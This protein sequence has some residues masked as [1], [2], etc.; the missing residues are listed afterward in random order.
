M[1]NA[2]D[3]WL[4]A[5]AA[6]LQREAKAGAVT[7]HEVSLREVLRHFGFQKRGSWINSRIEDALQARGLTMSPPIGE[8]WYVDQ[9]VSITREGDAEAREGDGPVLEDPTVRVEILDAAERSLVTVTPDASLESAMT[10]MQLHDYSQLPVWSTPS[11]VKGIVSW[12]SIGRAH[13]HGASPLRAGE[14]MDRAHVIPVHMPLMEAV[15]SIY[16]HDCVLVEGAGRQITGIVTAADLALMFK[17]LAQAFLLIGEIEQH[18]RN[19]VRGKF[20]VEELANA[21]G[22]N[23][24]VHGP[25]DLSFGGVVRL[26]QGKE[27]WQKLGLTVDRVVFT[28]RLDAIRQIR[29]R[30]MHFSLEAPDASE[31]EGLEKTADF[32]RTLVR[33]RRGAGVSGKS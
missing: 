22:G 11:S 12:K 26:L 28:G 19:L 20:T 16:K 21:A 9:T 6:R 14:C 31:I 13:A 18:L 2:G 29:N 17:Q 7:R 15:D 32:F 10:L 33:I 8:P 5:I 3:D 30:V 23:G 27:A 4:D 24:D 25:A 1:S